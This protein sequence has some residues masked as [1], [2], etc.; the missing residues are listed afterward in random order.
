MTAN[1]EAIVVRNKF[2]RSTI[3]LL[4]RKNTYDCGVKLHLSR[5][6]AM[7]D[8]LTLYRFA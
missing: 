2:G 7:N 6:L 3:S 4:R 8:R 5:I 1:H